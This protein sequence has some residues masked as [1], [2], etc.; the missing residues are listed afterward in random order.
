MC[1]FISDRNAFPTFSE[2]SVAVRKQWR[3]GYYAIL[4]VNHQKKT[5]NR[6]WNEAKIIAA[7]GR[8]PL[9]RACGKGRLGPCQQRD[10][11]AMAPL[12]PENHMMIWWAPE[13]L[14]LVRYLQITKAPE[15]RLARMQGHTSW[16]KGDWG[17]L[18]GRGKRKWLCTPE[19]QGRH[20]RHPGRGRH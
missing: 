15:G 3:G 5:S 7:L 17:G 19:K 2:C 1:P 14:M 11:D 16:N 6:R 20:V 10:L 13:I 18:M 4:R 9:K 8:R 12:R